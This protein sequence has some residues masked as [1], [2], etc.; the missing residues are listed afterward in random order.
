MKSSR[1]ITFDIFTLDPAN[2]LL[3][4]GKERIHLRPKTYALLEYLASHPGRLA[5]KE[6]LLSAVW[7]DLHVGDEALKHCMAEIRRALND[8]AGKPRFIE[9]VHRRGYRFIAKVGLRSPN[10]K[11][12]SGDFRNHDPKIIRTGELVGRADELLR[13]RQFLQRALQNERQTVFIHGEQGIGKTS[14]VDAFLDRVARESLGKSRSTGAPLIARG[15]CVYS[16]GAGEAYMPIFEALTGL[17]RGTGRRIIIPA[18]RRHAPLWL[19]QMPALITPSQ[20][21]DLRRLTLGATRERMLRELAEALES[22]TSET[23]LILVLEDLHWSDYSTLDLISYWTRR[24]APSRLLLIGT[25]RPAEGMKGGHPLRAL[26]EELQAHPQFQEL[27]LSSLDESAIEKYLARRFQRHAF[28]A[29]TPSL[30]RRLTGGNPLFMINMLDYLLSGGLIARRDEQWTLDPVPDSRLSVPPTIQQIIE[31]QIERCS[32]IERQVLQ[33]GSV[34]GVEFSV[35]GIAAALEER[36]DRVDALCRGLA[37]RNQFIKPSSARRIDDRRLFNRYVFLHDLY[38]SILYDLL[39][40][41]LRVGFH[42]RLAGHI[43]RTYGAKR[44]ELAARLAMHF[45]RGL[46]PDRAVRYYLRAAENANARYAGREALA[47]AQ[48]GLELL[49]NLPDSP[50]RTE[51]ELSL[52]IALG[53]ALM[54]AQGLGAPEV[55]EAFERARELFQNIS[56][57]QRSAKNKFLF[58]ALY[59]LWNYHWVRA[60]Y[61]TARALA[62]QMLEIAESAKDP[63]ML[64]QAHYSLGIILMDHG[65]FVVAFEHLK[66]TTGIVGRCCAA[67]AEWNLGYPDKALDHALETLEDALKTRNPENCIFAHQGTARVYMARRESQ[68]ALDRAQ[69]ALDL[70]LQHGLTE[71]WVAPMRCIRGWALTKLGRVK[72]GFEQVGQSLAVFREIGATNLMPLLAVMFAEAAMDAGEFEKGLAAIEEALDASRRTGMLHSD[73]ELHRLRGELLLRQAAGHEYAGRNDPPSQEA[74]SCFRQA[75]DVARSQG[76]KSLELRAALSLAKLLRGSGQSAEARDCLEPIFQWFSEGQGTPDL[77][78]ARAF[79]DELP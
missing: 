53:A 23:P 24:R 55:K 72:E 13:L 21:E 77:L 46:E 7:R 40:A 52:H 76:A 20:M 59:G 11:K 8:E 6:E 64:S 69:S 29:E 61:E 60:E 54:S 36:E 5:T 25:Y 4:K 12:T 70:A 57:P 2:E 44:D 47:L 1:K 37:D 14:L 45:D 3:W 66:R 26:R 48:R 58:P 30:I 56:E 39:P 71:Q 74:E 73:A 17:C 78:E 34:E 51:S 10:K 16:H 15:Q 19:A 18:L 27:P 38:R 35:N 63:T 68:K 31:R 9:T 65:E 41:E 42:R 28:P 67:I 43:E 49:E 79:L 75:V 33:A 32:P 62:E 22:L 50:E